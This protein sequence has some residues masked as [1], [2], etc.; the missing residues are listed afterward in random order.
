MF[1]I[2]VP[3]MILILAVAL[4]VIGPKKLPD[5]AKSMGR[6]LGEFKKATRDFKDSMEVEEEFKELNEVK[7][8]FQDISGDIKSNLTDIAKD[9]S[10]PQNDSVKESGKDLEEKS[11]KDPEL[12]PENGPGEDLEKKPE[13]EQELKPE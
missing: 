10:T 11:G 3:E 6:A 8:A 1:G 13:E 4:V 7:T 12:E 2:G 5:L 9:E